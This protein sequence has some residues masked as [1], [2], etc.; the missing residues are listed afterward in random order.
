MTKK[1][2]TLTA[3]VIMGI[4]MVL[5]FAG[6]PPM[7][8]PGASW[9]DGTMEGMMYFSRNPSG[10]EWPF[11]LN[12]LLVKTAIKFNCGMIKIFCPP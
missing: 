10:A 5:S 1:R 4:G 7:N 8:D 9:S 12:T 3:T 6:C 11:E 2:I